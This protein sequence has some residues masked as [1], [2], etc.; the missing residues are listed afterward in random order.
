MCWSVCTAGT[1]GTAAHHCHIQQASCGFA[2]LML[3]RPLDTL[4]YAAPPPHSNRS[5]QAQKIGPA[6]LGVHPG[7]KRLPHRRQV[8]QLSE[9]QVQ[10][11]HGAE[12]GRVSPEGA[13][14]G[15]G[16]QTCRV[17]KGQAGIEIVGR[18]GKGGAGSAGSAG[19]HAGSSRAVAGLAV[20]TAAPAAAGRTPQ[21]EHSAAQARST[22]D[23][24]RGAR[25]SWS[26]ALV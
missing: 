3:E 11:S 17:T 12:V 2:R 8:C 7:V 4:L 16:L 24:A 20:A 22:S 18:T 26:A 23:A 14:A 13:A 5:A 19:L 1:A 10:V 6:H 21:A 9:A 25:R 15:G